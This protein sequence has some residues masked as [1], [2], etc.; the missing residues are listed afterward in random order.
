MR[1]LVVSALHYDLPQLDWVVRVAP[2]FDL[3]VL[4]G[5][6]LDR[7]KVR[8]QFQHLGLVGRVGERHTADVVRHVNVS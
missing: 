1:I 4:A 3:V 6:H 8:S 5:D 7:G 2:D